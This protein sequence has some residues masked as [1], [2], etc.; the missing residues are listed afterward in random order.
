MDDRSPTMVKRDWY[1]IR[2]PFVIG[3]V[4]SLLFFLP[5]QQT[6][7]ILP[8]GAAPIFLLA[9]RNHSRHKLLL[10]RLS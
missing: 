9:S 3:D 1:G 10:C 8:D 4:M 2:V 7:V 6:A 5:L